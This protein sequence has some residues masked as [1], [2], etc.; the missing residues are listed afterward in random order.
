MNNAAGE[1]EPESKVFNQQS[2]FNN[3]YLCL[4]GE[5]FL[6]DSAPPRCKI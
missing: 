5:E 2:K 3:A 1:V 4:R 6:D